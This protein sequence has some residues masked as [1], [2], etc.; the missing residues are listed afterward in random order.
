VKVLSLLSK[1]KA[2]LELAKATAIPSLG[3]FPAIQLCTRG[4]M[5]MSTNWFILAEVT[6]TGW[7]SVAD[8]PGRGALS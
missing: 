8:V 6:V 2:P 3:V 1:A 4:V 7:P 5:S